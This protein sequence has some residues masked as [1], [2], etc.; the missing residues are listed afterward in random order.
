V[1]KAADR[2]RLA[3]LQAQRQLRDDNRA[4]I[5]I[6]AGVD[7][8]GRHAVINALT[9]GLDTR[10]VR[11][12]A[13]T[14]ESVPGLHRPLFWRYWQAL[15]A[16][17]QVGIFLDGWYAEPMD[18]AFRGDAHALDN[19][20]AF[21]AGL[22]ADGA[23]LVKLWVTMGAGTAR[24]QIR[25]RL[26]AEARL[27]TLSEQ[28]VLAAQDEAD[29]RLDALRQQTGDWIEL[30]CRQPKRI[31]KAA[32][33][34]L[35]QALQG[36]ALPQP[37]RRRLPTVSKAARLAKIDLDA[38]LGKKTAEREIEA[39]QA[40]LARRLWAAHRR[41]QPVVMLMEGSD[42]A[43]KGGVIRRVTHPLDARL[44][45][46]VPIAAPTDEERAH[47]YLWRFWRHLP[48]DGH[49]T[50]FDRSWYGRVLVERVEGFAQP[51]EW[52]RAY[53]EIND[54]EAQLVAHGTALVKVWLHISPE[55]QLRRF[56]ARAETPHKQHK[57]TDEDWRNREKWS[58]CLTATDEMIART[59][60]PAAPWTLVAANDKR[61]ARRAVLQTLVNALA[62]D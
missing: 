25:K 46:V 12:N 36:L 4:L 30:D 42:A 59:D 34:G 8:A 28:C 39:L 55:E 35:T 41:E 11:V 31:E 1:G 58:E 51:H 15:P 62:A 27:P 13:W 40:E 48:R 20:Q 22:I 37:K 43:G 57:L 7:G 6:V 3:L 38:T 18:A 53:A 14:P 21:E 5:V 33:E 32:V 24:K 54:F 56:E 2:R 49:M 17:G 61:Y 60:T 50:I 45:Q 26:K 9:Q 47:P 10:G 29:G 44:F 52:Q 16:R 23:V 19:L